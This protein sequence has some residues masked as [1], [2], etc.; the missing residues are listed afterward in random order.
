MMKMTKKINLIKICLVFFSL[1]FTSLS[2]VSIANAEHVLNATLENG[3]QRIVP[4]GTT[5]TLTLMVNNTAGSTND[6][7]GVNITNGTGYYVSSITATGW[8]CTI[9]ASISGCVN[10]TTAGIAA[11]SYATFTVAVTTPTAGTS[12]DTIWLIN[13]TDTNVGIRNATLYML[14]VGTAEIGFDIR[15]ELGNILTGANVTVTSSAGGSLT[16]ADNNITDNGGEDDTYTDGLVLFKGPDITSGAGEDTFSYNVSRAGFVVAPYIAD[17]SFSSTGYHMIRPTGLQY[18]IKIT[19]Q[20]QLANPLTGA[21]VNV[22]DTSGAIYNQTS[23]SSTIWPNVTNTGNY[24]FALGNST[25]FDNVT[26]I[27]SKSGFINNGSTNVSTA[28]TFYLTNA[29]QTV[30]QTGASPYTLKYSLKVTAQNELFGIANMNLVTLHLN[31]TKTTP[32]ASS[33]NVYYFNRSTDANIIANKTGYV[34]TTVNNIQT[35]SSAQ[36]VVTI[37]LP[38]VLKIITQDELLSNLTASLATYVTN[39]STTTPTNTTGGYA[40]FALDPSS[41]DVNVTGSYAGYVNISTTGL[42]IN[43]TTQA[44]GSTTLK[45]TVKVTDVWDELNITKFTI[46]G[47]DAFAEVLGNT[48]TYSGGAAYIPIN[49]SFT[50]SVV[51]GRSSFVNA[52]KQIT[53]SSGQQTILV[54]NKSSDTGNATALNYTFKVLGVWS[55]LGRLSFVLDGTKNNAGIE[56]NYSGN[57]VYSGGYA[58]LNISGTN[59]SLTAYKI[60]QDFVNVSKDVTPSALSQ[61]TIL[62]NASNDAGATVLAGGLKYLLKVNVTD[63]LSGITNMDSNVFIY[64]NGT[65]YTPNATA[66]TLYYFTNNTAVTPSGVNITVGRKGYINTS[67]GGTTTAGIKVNA[68]T[69]GFYTIALPFALKIGIKNELG[70]NLVA[71]SASIRVNNISFSPNATSGPYAYFAYPPQAI[72]VNVSYTGYVNESTLESNV[73]NSSTQAWENTTLDFTLKVTEIR[74]ELNITKFTIDGSPTTSGSAFAEVLGNTTTYSGGAAYINTS[75]GLTVNVVAGASGFV[76]ESTIVT[77]SSSAQKLIV[78]NQSGA[79]GYQNATG[80]GLNFTVKVL[81]ICDEIDRMC[82]TIDSTPATIGHAGVENTTGATVNTTY[83]GGYAYLNA[84]GSIANITAFSTGFINRS[85]FVTLTPGT[86]QQLIWFNSSSYPLLY[87]LK[88]NVTDELGQSTGM[89]SNV[90]L[91]INSTWKNETHEFWRSASTSNIYYFNLSAGA[92]GYNVTGAKVGYINTTN[93]DATGFPV[94]ATKQALQTVQLPYVAKVTVR[95]QN[96]DLMNGSQLEIYDGSGSVTTLFDGSSSDGDTSANGVIYYALNKSAIPTVNKFS[97][98]A[99]SFNGESTNS[100]SGYKINDTAQTALTIKTTAPRPYNFTTYF[101]TANTW[102]TFKIA[103]QSL[104]QSKGYTV[105]STNGWNVST[106]LTT[107]GL[108]TN[109]D[110]VYYEGTTWKVFIRTDW[111]GSSLQY[112]NNTNQYDYHVNTTQSAWFIL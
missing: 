35:N 48:T 23:G 99:G 62:F 37:K 85:Q 89:S 107:A 56:A 1:L 76:N 30:Q 69:Q 33:V 58:Y 20:D 83:V 106:V 103:H 96:N 26:F 25:L 102:S 39:S 74:D 50:V 18:D 111:A 94:N 110:V 36:A 7:I 57:T 19:V 5:A 105:A 13:T 14:A 16:I 101:L 68:S 79:T 53:T 88:V 91:A 11:N 44:T 40:F 61:Q 49:N 52:S 93:G 17:V 9:G 38:F 82:F 15:D 104:L 12:G 100:S 64:Q 70:T 54:F 95:A 47:T 73:I 84:S 71:S 80:G 34:N 4:T 97:V 86:V 75:N 65:I 10:T 21:T 67:S 46:D 60:G 112:V 51:A 22:T 45:F 66:G 42:L 81:S 8:S 77:A 28:G 59:A 24:Y 27:F 63:E 92:D 29:T 3:T 6:I 2:F 87:A 98:T 43:A 41:G 90:S 109:Y 108:G 31:N 55:E 78:F 32:D 72:Y